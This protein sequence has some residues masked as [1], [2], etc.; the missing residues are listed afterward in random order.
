VEARVF[1]GV[2]LA[3]RDLSLLRREDPPELGELCLGDALGGEGRDRWLDEAAEF[4]D[5]RERVATRDET[6]ER[7]RQ[8][9]RG[10]LPNEG[11][12]TGARLDDAEELERAQRLAN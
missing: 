1:I 12:A 10:S 8:I 7:T 2:R 11:A 3:R 6:G 5:V 4:D 9:V